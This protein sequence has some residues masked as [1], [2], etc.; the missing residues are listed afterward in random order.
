MTPTFEQFGIWMACALFA[1][2]VYL[3]LRAAQSAKDPQKRDVRISADCATREEFDEHV[4][5]NRAAH[6]QIFSEI[7]EGDADV[8]KRLDAVVKE[9]NE[10]LRALPNEIIAL[11][12]N[13][14]ALK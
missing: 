4:R 3:R 5:T 14:G 9:F 7:K 8:H 6:N 13:T 12:R 11:L 1:L 10:Q 2:D